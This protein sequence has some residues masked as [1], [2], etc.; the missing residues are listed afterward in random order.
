MAA[1]FPGLIRRPIAKSILTAGGL[2]KR[3][4]F[5]TGQMV[6]TSSLTT[7]HLVKFVLTSWQA[8]EAS[9]ARQLIDRVHQ[10]EGGWVIGGAV[11][12]D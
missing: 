8:H 12:G 6:G 5:P 3:C 7:G 4:G 9:L 2:R 11:I 10:G 1:D